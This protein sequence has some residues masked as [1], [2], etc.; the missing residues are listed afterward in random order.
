MC[1]EGV[2]E[3]MWLGFQEIAKA[4]ELISKHDP[5]LGIPSPDMLTRH[6]NAREGLP[7]WLYAVEDALPKCHE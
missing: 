7:E 3:R 5:R 4:N 1:G 6:L 2:A